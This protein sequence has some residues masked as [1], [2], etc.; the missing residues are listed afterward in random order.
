MNNKQAVKIDRPAMWENPRFRNWIAV[1]RA[2]HLV[3]QELARK[4]KPLDLKTPHLDIL[5]N[6]TRTP[7]ISQQDLAHKLFVGRSNMTMLL[8]HLEKRG[9]VERRPDA[10]DRRV[11]RLFLTPE[12]VALA[13]R[14]IAVQA[15]IIDDMMAATSPEECEMVGDSMRRIV[16]R[17]LEMQSGTED[18]EEE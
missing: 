14:A 2:C 10:A 3:Q 11:L 18:A 16:A 7:G 13:D 8:P 4:L 9:L 5:V 15:K 17:L 12:G 6:L 1:A